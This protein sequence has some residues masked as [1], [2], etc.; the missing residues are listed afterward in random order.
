VLVL[1]CGCS[2][3]RPRSQDI[4]EETR[5]PAYGQP[6]GAGIVL[7][8]VTVAILGGYLI[9]KPADTCD[10][11]ANPECQMENNGKKIVEALLG[12]PVLLGGVAITGGGVTLTVVTVK[13]QERRMQ[14]LK[15]RCKGGDRQAC[16]L[17]Q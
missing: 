14:E 13:C 12:V 8:G 1:A 6:L 10:T 7:A 2:A 4:D 3:V 17:L 16:L 5:C 11:I 9:A 15:A